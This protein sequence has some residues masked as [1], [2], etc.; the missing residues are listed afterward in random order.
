MNENT[1]LERIDL[2]FNNIGAGA[3]HYIAEVERVLRR[4]K[5]MRVRSN[6]MILIRFLVPSISR[7]NILV[8][9]RIFS[10]LIFP[11]AYN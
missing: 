2:K 7:L 6:R 4:N 11:F 9:H 8:D 10:D 1:S 5:D 3:A